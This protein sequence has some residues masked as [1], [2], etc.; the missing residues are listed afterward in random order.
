MTDPVGNRDT[1]SVADPHTTLHRRERQVSEPEQG[2]PEQSRPEQERPGQDR[3]K[4]RP[5]QDKVVEYLR[6]VT[7]DLKRSRQRVREL[8]DREHEP[9]AI[10]G[11]ACRYPGGV[12]SP[13]DLWR[14]VDG[15]R[16]AMAEF[17]RDRGWP[18][19]LYHPD[20]DHPGTSYAR[21][22]G[23]LYEAPEFDAGF[24]DIS[25]REALAMDPQQRQLLETAWT[26]AE[27][28]GIDPLALRGTDTGVFVGA[29]YQ[30]YA[31]RQST[32]PEEVAG[33]LIS[34]SA[35]SV[36]S[37]RI[38][39]ALG[40]V[41]P[42]VTVDTACSSS[43]VAIHLAAQALRA[44]ECSLAMAGGV[45]VM[46]TPTL[47]LEFSRQRGLA[48]D[49]RC[50]SFAAAADGTGWSEGVGLVLLER[51]SEARRHGHRVL[52]V[53]RGSAVNQDGASNG[54]TAPN[55]PSQ[56]R[57]I[58]RA[59]ANARLT[60]QDVDLLE[61]HGTGT[62]LGDPIEAEALLDT[63][64]RD[65]ADGPPLYLG[66]VKSNIGHTQ[67]AA[68]VAGVIKAV[69]AMR[70]GVLPRTL[71]VDAPSPHVDWA[72]GAVSLLSEPVVWPET[73]RPRRAAVSAFGISGTNA[74]LVL[75][76]APVVE[77]PADP[78]PAGRS[79]AGGT[80]PWVVSGRGPEALRT[81][82]G[83]LAEFL[84]AGTG[85]GTG[86]G[87]GTGNG[88][89]PADV[90]WS[91][92][93]TR[94][95]L[96][97]RAVVLGDS[98]S[99]LLAG[100]RAVASGAAHPAVVRAGDGTGTGRGVAFLFTGQGA[101]RAGMGAGAAEAFPVF[102]AALDEVCAEF[103]PLLGVPLREAMA[104]GTAADGRS[105]D[106]TD[107]AQP[108][109]FALQV[110]LVR[111]AGSWGVRPAAVAGHS[112]G[113]LT[114]AHVAGVWSLPDACAVVA[115][116]GRL[117]QAL[118]AGGAMLA[119]QAG[120]EQVLG[121]VAAQEAR[122]PG[123]VAVAAVNGPD[124]VVVSGRADAV[125]E[126]GRAARAAG[127][128]V[129]ALTVSHAFHSPLM[130]P[131][132]GA[133]A[134][135]LAGV[136]TRSPGLPGV[137]AVTG[138]WSDAASWGS[139]A[140]WVDQVCAPVRF[141]DVT[142]V[143][144]ADGFDTCLEAGPDGVLSA[145]VTES[146]AAGRAGGAAQADRDAR[147]DRPRAPL[148]VPLLRR[149]RSERGAA[150][151]AAA[152][153]FTAGVPVDWAGVVAAGVD[154]SP[155]RVDLP[156]Y[157]FRSDRYWLSQEDAVEAGADRTGQA[158]P[159]FWRL[160]E[161]GDLEGLTAALELPG[162]VPLSRAL[163][164]LSSRHRSQRAGEQAADWLYRTRWQR[165][166]EARPAATPTA[167]PG[168]NW[169]VVVP[170]GED[171][172]QW[173]D[174]VVGT[175]RG[176]VEP[177]VVPVAGRAELA[178][179]IR[180]ALGAGP[181]DALGG[182][183]APG[184]ALAGVLC[185]A[186]VDERPDPDHPEITRGLAGALAVLQSAADL[187]L[188]VPLWTATRD[189]VPATPEDGLG[190]YAQAPLWGLG[191][192]AR[193]E[194]PLTWG[195]LVDLPAV[196]DEWTGAR[197]AGL[198]TGAAGEDQAAI[199]G[200]AVFV[201]RLVRSRPGPTPPRWRPTGTV[202]VTGGTGAL[203]AEV[204]R[205]LAREGAGHLVLT[206]RRGPDA[207]GAG[208]LAAELAALGAEVS[209]EA[210]D[211]ADR[212][213]LAALLAALPAPVTAVVH[214]AGVLDDGVLTALTPGRLAEVARAKAA[215]ALNLHEVTLGTEL[216]AF[217]LFSS[218]AGTLGSAGQGN[219]AAANAFLDALAERR[220]REGLPATSI[221][222][223]PWAGAGMA[224]GDGARQKLARLAVEPM[225]TGP[226]L[227]ALGAAVGGGAGT[228]VVADVR[229]ARLAAG[230][231]PVPPLLADLPEARPEPGPGAATAVPGSA[232]HGLATLPPAQRERA[233]RDLVAAT[234]A[235]VLGHRDAV[236]VVA[237]KPFRELG[238]DSLTAVEL[239]N[240]LGTGLGLTLAPTL[241]FDHPSPQALAAHLGALL[242]ED[243]ENHEAPAKRSDRADRAA[244]ATGD[245]TEAD[246]DTDPVAI[247]SMDCRFPGGVAGPEDFWELLRT[248]R[249]A[250]SAFPADRG[251]D[252]AALYDPDP[253]R[254]GTSYTR[255]GAF[256]D[257][258]DRFDA[259]FFGI[260]AREAAAM[261]PQQRLLLEIAWQA[262]ERAGLDPL[263]LR[264]SRTGVFIG[265]NGQDYL[266]FVREIPEGLDG[267]LGTGNAASVLS[268]RLAYTLGLRGPAI[269]VDTACSSSLVALHL[270]ARS[271][272]QGECSLALVG[273]ATVM[274][275]P[276]VFV[277]FSRQRGLAEDGRCKPFA[278]GADGTGWGE[279]AGVLVLER[280]SD[281]RRH[282]HPVLAVLRGSAVNQDG[283]SNGLTAPNGPAQQR[284]IG[285][286][287]ADAGL[288]PAEV[289][290]VEAHGTG[291]RLGDPIEAQAL[292]AAYGQDR[293]AERPLYLGSVKSNI[294][295]T[296]AAAGLAGLI[297]MVLAMRHGVL[298]RTLH[299]DAPSPHV[300]WAS[301]A[302]SLVTEPV[303]WPET[304]RPRRA[305]VSSF[306][307]SGTNA[308]AIIEQAPEP[309]PA[310]EPAA[311]L[312]A[313][314]A[315]EP[316]A[317]APLPAAAPAPLALP[318]SARGADAL[319]AQARA[320][321]AHLGAHPDQTLA[322]LG[323]SLATGRAALTHRAV[324]LAED[325]AG[326]DAGL[327]AL[328]AGRPVPEVITGRVAAD[329]A[330]AFLF[331]GQ[332]SQRPG[333]GGEL[334]ASSAAFREAFDAVCDGLEPRLGH[335]VRGVLH[336]A[337]GSAEAALLDRTGHAQAALFALEV[338][339]FRLLESRGLVPDVVAGHSIGE[340]AAAHVAG[341]FDLADATALVA[342]RARLMEA[343]PPGG[344]MTAVE[345]G[346]E[347]VAELVAERA[348][349]LSVAAVNGPTATVLSGDEDAV[350]EV[351]A[352]LAARG[353]RT[354][355]LR[356]SHAFHSPHMAGMLAAF[357][358]EAERIG[359]HPPRIPLVSNLTGA[360][361]DPA[362]VAGA[363]YW[364]R[365]VREPVRFADGIRTLERRGV[366][367]FVEL[368]P[369][370]VLAAMTQDCL[371]DPGA[372]AAVP[373]LRADRP[374]G[375]ALTAALARLQVRGLPVDLTAPDGGG[376]R[377][378]LPVY[379]FQG[380]SHWL[381]GTRSAAGPSTAAT[382]AGQ[383]AFVGQD[384]FAGQDPDGKPD[385][386]PD[387]AETGSEAL[388]R[389]LREAPPASRTALLT[390]VVLGQVAAVL[391][392]PDE[393]A[394]PAD[395]FTELG[396]NSLGAAE[397]RTRL[398]EATG[399][400]LAP[401][402][403]AERPTGA[404]LAALLAERI[405]DAPPAGAAATPVTAEPSAG[406]PAT[407]LV[408]LF[409]QA[410]LAGRAGDGLRLLAAAAH[411]RDA[412]EATAPAPRRSRFAAGPAGPP[413]VCFPSLVAPAH[414]YQYARFATAFRGHRGLTVLA[415][416]GYAAGE[417]LP[418]T[419]AEF[420]DRQTAAVRADHG[421]RPVVLVG[422]S[423]GGWVAHAVA[424]ALARGGAAPAAV[425]L[426]DSHLPGSPGLTALES[427]LFTALAD[428]AELVEATTD[429]GLG[430]MGRHFDLFRD[431]RPGPVASPT[432][433]VRATEPLP[434]TP[435]G[436]A[437]PAA[438][439]PTRHTTLDVPA[440][441]LTIIG[442]SG[443]STGHAVESWLSGA[444]PEAAA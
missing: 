357:R 90:A 201:P 377:V 284:V 391:G 271:L 327:A 256:L 77:E 413:L 197:L 185:L 414:A 392:D 426:L 422:Y 381:S 41:G 395:T 314:P 85:T 106:R 55:G 68:G 46:S 128:R 89:D 95:A 125:E 100:L 281:A 76:Q 316:A 402:A 343:L 88:P 40:L 425:V 176:H 79:V 94:P 11:M 175:L 58:Q 211:V 19:D 51:L 265:T 225:A 297:K 21:A 17:P 247:V 87:A 294:G 196:P 205:W 335:S 378:D 233:L 221:A 259:A 274:A 323:W 177:L 389:R 277:D 25:P 435:A 204:A 328:A 356:V 296:Q 362:E 57:V 257:R 137:A 27:G 120:P 111:L 368:G 4:D 13:E 160:V 18:A 22:G 353:R 215:A 363:D 59:L 286:A 366:R 210:C 388:R 213:A 412:P 276:G 182:S 433:L 291:T 423:S 418:R 252:L 132:L 187:G 65:R 317:V 288:T 439:W 329:G 313:E 411:L 236:A 292:L 400:R 367:T 56:R 268:G 258:P 86:A 346:P 263:A 342:A 83:R 133:F 192:V 91:L 303:V 282:G 142:A 102:A 54:L 373:L 3:T 98:S 309:A 273:G 332:G 147:D 321:R 70:H 244:S 432:L 351:A 350:H 189:A 99:E 397:L 380:R 183:P 16:D 134:E 361:A 31:L 191:R 43:L 324:V 289:D 193:L 123:Q 285:E 410:S 231:T 139:A 396:L 437:V 403:V 20:P 168:G 279:G 96:E 49:G 179:R 310:P 330:V 10:V 322:D 42:A 241:A 206:G 401:S 34:G 333:M 184:R 140:Y 347:E 227:A 151:A 173:A 47:F 358:A 209:I 243:A 203:G 434:G 131:M 376:R 360:L 248:G 165:L 63:Y 372:A 73:G 15:G 441:H 306:G 220:V 354:K 127:C 138:G 409:R 80:L 239:R 341:V 36:V 38:S 78:A 264:E 178:D 29:M 109:L 365:H 444:V 359:Y 216:S 199:R 287:L 246:P 320:L 237:D 157:A 238:L 315:V 115:A 62:R 144:L 2:R 171:E 33:Y 375:A 344:A 200:A 355:R 23:F 386:K 234:T 188:A 385:G 153:L 214:A 334:Y 405:V 112:I 393:P 52:A 417:A 427:T 304:G 81:Q 340:L 223:G 202:L 39:Y 28:A 383:D 108:A 300:D 166:P 7:A 311:D 442:D 174:Q 75:E 154:G 104:T 126:V 180:T 382:A 369:D 158:D 229:W 308:H 420:V 443:P 429:A 24:F 226:A 269:T 84:T 217:V 337:P 339:L 35:D 37:G 148:A 181:A 110:A 155:R 186:G 336:A 255:H 240:A 163:P 384:A 406:P 64:G 101:Q 394:G 399:V 338:G 230:G 283:A 390:E 61:A 290:A 293:P 319:R 169:L 431:W 92:A 249:D 245:G 129:K 66:S 170:E 219:Y 146:V 119:V 408:T 150:L 162:D 32:V 253:D 12:R 260:G 345:A 14:L 69:M 275:G 436:P 371:T 251:W 424:E 295:H 5:E 352:V 301:G 212:A 82:A 262:V 149:G 167:T 302:V 156:T 349:R 218:V 374:D 6:R 228:A 136:S 198:L 60:T 331:T 164:A 326:F 370:A 398:H 364:V 113:E 9:I 105:L 379:Q 415:P 430:A 307:V 53:L 438:S 207:P 130:R 232:A 161:R 222:W 124:S 224:S 152:A 172:R 145:M 387:E 159:E 107:L 122:T 254:P 250:V 272:R 26:V 117:M 190:G 1:G 118:P 404:A 30:N 242:R 312:A 135:V 421:D 195:G 440:D 103:D 325:R 48:A 298:P 93:T 45:T 114:A 74:H 419:L 116:R 141:A 266:S 208:A 280:L 267:Y 235:Q 67:A 72:S 97:D 416:S 261:D 318:V 50:K 428:R 71:H 121:W 270:A 305:G 194:Q 278:A 299:V 407:P 348:D 44:G 8:E 143:L